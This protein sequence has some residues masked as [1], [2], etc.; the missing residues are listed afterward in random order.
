MSLNR[1]LWQAVICVVLLSAADFAWAL[2]CG[3]R[4]VKEGMSEAQVIELCG[5]PAS[6][7]E[8]GYV[9]R[10]YILKRPSPIGGP[11]ATRRVYAGFHQALD[12]RELTYNFGPHR[13][14]RII[15]FEGGVVKSIRKAGYGYHEKTLDTSD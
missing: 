5:D 12:V 13:F 15:R 10:P 9:L 7:T 2:R 1:Y 14:I 6:V 8:I 11:H 4:L 3:N